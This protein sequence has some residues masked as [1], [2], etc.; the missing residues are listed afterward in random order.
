VDCARE[1]AMFFGD[2]GFEFWLHHWD[3]KESQ[4]WGFYGRCGMVLLTGDCLFYLMVEHDI[5]EV[6]FSGQFRNLRRCGR[7]GAT[8]SQAMHAFGRHY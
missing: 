2:I 4:D 5:L 6:L 3:W 1:R 8:A 7:C